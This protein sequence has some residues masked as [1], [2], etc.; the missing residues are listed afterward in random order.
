[1]LIA[2]EH[3]ELS[4]FLVIIRYTYHNKSMLKF[5]A[6]I[7]TMVTEATIYFLA[8][9]TMQTYVLLSLILMEGTSQQLS[10][11]VYGLLNPILTMRFAVSLKRSADPDGR[12]EWQLMHFSSANFASSLSDTQVSTPTVQEDVEMELVDPLDGQLVQTCVP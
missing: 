7:R 3:L 1:V 5:S 9:V 12:Q 2:G 10:F 4:A 11:A 8:I 6:L